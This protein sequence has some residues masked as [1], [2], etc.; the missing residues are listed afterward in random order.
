MAKEKSYFC[1]SECGYQ[2]PKQMG[3]CPGCNNWNTLTEELIRPDRPKVA[4]PGRELRAL[5]D[6]SG[7]ETMRFQSGNYEL[8]RVLGGGIVPGSLI[9]LGGE[10]GIGKSTLLLQIA[11]YLDKAGKKVLYLSGEESSRQIKMRADRLGIDGRNIYII[12]EANLDF[13]AGYI[14]QIKPDLVIVD[15]IQTVYIPEIGSIPGSV[16]QLRESAARVMEIAKKTDLPFVLIGHVTKEGAIAGPKVLEHLVDTVIYF[17]GDTNNFYR[18][19]RTVKNRFGPANEM[20]ILE[21]SGQGLIEVDNPSRIFLRHRHGLPGLAVVA[22]FEGTRPIL[23][24]VEALVVPSVIGYPRRMAS[25]IEG[26]R[27]SLLVAV[28]EK[29]GGLS[30]GNKD[31]YIKVAGGASLKDPATDLGVALAMASSFYD[32]P[33]PS[34]S[35]V[36]GELGL[37]GE[38]RSVSNLTLRLK[39]AKKLGFVRA[40]IP[41][42]TG[43][44]A[45]NTLGLEVIPVDTLAEALIK[46]RHN[47]GMHFEG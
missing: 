46:N 7:E 31:V 23:V 19:L 39:E 20:G 28:L 24:E 27:L 37:S 6:V 16:A 30:M 34:G 8:D 10:P 4:F 13:L 45:V 40:L 29:R 9:L 21:M 41:N 17:E 5:I 14:D 12:N 1:C 43:Q 11:D 42:E 44:E 33:L 25:G 15:S 32:T 35:I 38:V 3:R 22:S 2:S 18:I 26:N 47:G 36:V